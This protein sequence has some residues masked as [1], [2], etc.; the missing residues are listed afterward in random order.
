MTDKRKL[1][2]VFHVGPHKTATTTFQSFLTTNT[3]TLIAQGTLVPKWGTI[4][5]HQLPW[6]L[7]GFD[8]NLLGALNLPAHYLIKSMLVQARAFSSHRIVLSSED[9]SLLSMSQWSEIRKI[10]K[11]ENKHFN[12]KLKCVY[13]LRRGKDFQTSTYWELVKHGYSKT[14]LESESAIRRH[15]NKTKWK[16]RV[17]PIAF[18]VEVLYHKQNHEKLMARIILQDATLEELTFHPARHNTIPEALSVLEETRKANE[19]YGLGEMKKLFH[20]PPVFTRDSWSE[21]QDKHSQVIL[22]Q[23]TE[24]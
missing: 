16:L 19:L 21:L 8:A 9:F 2:I 14:L 18:K 11:R 3:A 4:G 7:M 10:I 17:L 1:E 22:S 5:H 24:S 20:W 15:I 6:A 13:T 23:R 12:I